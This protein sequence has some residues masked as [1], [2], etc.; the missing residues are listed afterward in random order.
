[1]V[2]LFELHSHFRLDSV[3]VLTEYSLQLEDSL[4]AHQVNPS[5]N[6][7]V[8]LVELCPNFLLGPIA[9][10]YTAPRSGTAKPT[11]SQSWRS[12]C[13]DIKAPFGA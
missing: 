9:L 11:R 5:E 3:V 8:D 13:I 12:K 7:Q 6:D 4:L 10:A 1:M 2:S